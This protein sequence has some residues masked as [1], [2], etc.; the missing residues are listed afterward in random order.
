MNPL[1][2]VPASFDG[3]LQELDALRAGLIPLRTVDTT[4]EQFFDG[5]L[6]QADVTEMRQHQKSHSPGETTGHDLVT[7]CDIEEM[8]DDASLTSA[9]DLHTIGAE[10]KALKTFTFLALLRIVRWTEARGILPPSQNG[11]RKG[12]RTTNNVFILRC[13]IDKARSLGK[14]LYVATIDITNAFPS[15]NRPTLWLKLR[16]LGMQGRIYD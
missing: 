3:I 12:Y 2:P 14:T 9:E 6:T 13:L 8:D 15:T 5:P 7:D 11:F 16:A 4:A 1:N 10:S